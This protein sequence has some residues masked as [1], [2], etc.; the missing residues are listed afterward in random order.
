[1]HSSRRRETLMPNRGP[2]RCRILR[3]VVA[4]NLEP[5][6]L[7]STSYTI[8]DIGTLP[9]G[10]SSVATAINASGEV[11]GYSDTDGNNDRDHAFTWT[12]SG[13][14]HDLGTL[15][16]DVFSHAEA[17]NSAGDVVGFSRDSQGIDNAVLWMPG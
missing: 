12:A 15:P 1:M 13:G 3:R 17:I 7:L 2:R 16:G 4:E 8:T 6:R 10:T 11:A 14:L 9:G 5:R